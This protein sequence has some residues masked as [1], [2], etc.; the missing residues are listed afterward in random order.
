[1]FTT[2]EAAER[3]EAELEAFFAR[4][5]HLNTLDEPEF[6]CEEA[7]APSKRISLDIELPF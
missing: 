1:M 7:Q 3:Y 2:V 6:P 5:P 4:Y